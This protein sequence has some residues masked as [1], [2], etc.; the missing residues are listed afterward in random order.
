MDCTTYCQRYTDCSECSKDSACQFSSRN[1]GC[2]AAAAYVYDFGCPRPV[3]P[4]ITKLITRGEQAFNREATIDGYD[5]SAVLRVSLDRV[6]LTCPCD[7]IYR[8]SVAIYSELMSPI[9][10]LEDVPPRLGH[11]H[12]FV[13]LPGLQ[14]NTV[15][16]IHSFLCLKQGTLGRDNCS[17][18]RIERFRLLLPAGALPPPSAPPAPPAT[19]FGRGL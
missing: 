10:V 13:D 8:I 19:P 16:N 5:S 1:G 3:F 11:H 15:Y 17:P 12:T 2:V 7:S 6:D 18:A 4:L 9:T 14:N